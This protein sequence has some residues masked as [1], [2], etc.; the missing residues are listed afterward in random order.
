MAED[1]IVAGQ[2]KSDDLWDRALRPQRL[3]EYIGQEKVKERLSVFT[4][5]A[6]GRSE[7]LDHVLL[8]GPPGLG[9]T[10]LGHIIANELGVGIRFTSGPAIERPGDLAAILTNLDDREVL[11]IDEVHRLNR[12]VEEVL[13]PSME[14]FALDLVL[15]KGPSARSLRLDLPRFTLVGATTRAGM[16]TSP[17]RDRFGVI[18]HLDF[19]PADELAVIV[20]RSAEL[21]GVEVEDGVALE[22]A[23]RSRGTPRVANRLLKR[24]RDYAQVRAEGR[25][26]RTVLEE[27]LSLLDVDLR[28]LDAVDRRVLEAVGRRYGGGPVGLETLAAAV[29]EEPGTLEDVV[30]PYV[31]QMG[32]MERTPRGRQL[33]LEGYRYLGL[34]PP[35][36][37]TLLPLQ[38]TDP[39]P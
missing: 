11:F 37:Q 19:Y 31:L 39:E 15:G 12:T 27:G 24:L 14:D 21:L 26:T 30:E 38:E 25:L 6:I 28:G 33:T 1:R 22:I 23:R 7:P 3:G 8:Y 35:A 29:G 13:Y 20:T 32:L 10:T 9:K 36:R 17:L 4:E 34:E 5:A 18:L 2:L 16:L